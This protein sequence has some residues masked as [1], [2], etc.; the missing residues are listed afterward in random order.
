MFGALVAVTCSFTWSISIVLFKKTSDAQHPVVLNLFKNTIGLLLFIPTVLFVEGWHWPDISAVH[1]LTLFASG[2]IGIGAA[3]AMVLKALRQAGA[4]RVAIVECTYSPFVIFLSLLFLGEKLTVARVAG[5]AMVLAAILCVSVSRD[6]FS[7][8]TA[9]IASGLRWGVLGLFTMAA[10][11][12]MIKPLFAH[13][14][15]LWII[16]L[17][18]AAGVGASL[19]LFASL[20][21]RTTLLK[22]VWAI[23]QRNTM[24]FASVLSTYV[25]MSLWVAGYKFNDAALAAVLNQTSTIFTVI[26]AA[27]VLKE[28]FTPLKAAGTALA[29]AGVLVMALA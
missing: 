4:S 11:I 27:L 18:M 26:L 10:G 29:V 9:Q 6:A 23:P 3:D 5:T 21:V 22:Q 7:K 25:S 1:L 24:I 20:K 13:I 14:P 8:S 17:R 19:A 12:V 28:R 15:L 16:T 2:A